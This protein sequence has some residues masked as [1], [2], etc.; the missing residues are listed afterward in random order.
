MKEKNQL[1]EEHSSYSAGMRL[2]T[3]GLFQRDA[4]GYL[5]YV[6]RDRTPQEINPRAEER[7]LTP[8]HEW[9]QDGLAWIVTNEGRSE[10]IQVRTCEVSH[11][12]CTLLLPQQVVSGTFLDLSVPGLADP[13]D[14]PLLQILDTTPRG[15]IWI[16]RG[17]WLQELTAAEV[18]FLRGV[19]ESNRP[20]KEMEEPRK[21]EGWMMRLWRRFRAA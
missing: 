12:G 13:G 14:L 8:R 16:V 6:P 2:R 11:G 4:E 9:R 15:S 5:V 1:Y 21:T 17:T 10:S 20:Q 7:R 3:L 19:R 18:R